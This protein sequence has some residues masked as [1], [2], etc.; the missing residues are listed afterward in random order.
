MNISQETAAQQVH[1]YSSHPTPQRDT[2]GFHA[3]MDLHGLYRYEIR[4]TDTDYHDRLHLASLFALMQEAAYHNAE[5]LGMGA[6]QL[7]P[8][9]YCWL[10]ARISVRMVRLPRWTETMSV[11]TWSRGPRKLLF[12]RDFVFYA[13]TPD[14][15]EIIGQATSE[16]LIAHKETHRPVRPDK[17]LDPEQLTAHLSQPAALGFDCPKLPAQ[18]AFAAEQAGNTAGPT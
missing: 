16:W 6:G 15:A 5:H 14:Q 13:G 18:L 17:L 12:L 8:A 3:G 4:G 7:D 2:A 11:E 9:G 1:T 10:L